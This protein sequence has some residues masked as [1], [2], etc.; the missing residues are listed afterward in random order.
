MPIVAPTYP[1]TPPPTKMST[2]RHQIR[3]IIEAAVAPKPVRVHEEWKLKL[4][5]G[6]STSLLRP[7]G[8][9]FIHAWMIG[10]QSIIPITGPGGDFEFVGGVRSDR[11]FDV[12]I[13]GFFDYAILDPV[14]NMSSQEIVEQECET[15]ADW[16]K[17]N[18]NNLGLDA[19]PGDLRKVLPMR[20]DNI[21]NHDFAD[22]TSLIVAQCVLPIV[23][24]R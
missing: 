10:T 14:E 2:L 19:K 6:S 7:E 23:L 8:E 20:V 24:A 16:L 3:L 11:T 21:D 13:W 4:D 15:I 9:N 17:V 5:I 18:R 22:G 1:T 12:T